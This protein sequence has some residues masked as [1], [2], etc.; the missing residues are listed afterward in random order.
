MTVQVPSIKFAEPKPLIG[1]AFHFSIPRAGAPQTWALAHFP[2]VFFIRKEEKAGGR[3]PGEEGRQTTKRLG[4]GGPPLLPSSQP[5]ATGR[6]PPSPPDISPNP[7][8]SQLS[9]LGL[10]E[11]SPPQEATAG[12]PLPPPPPSAGAAAPQCARGRRGPVACGASGPAERG[13]DGGGPGPCRAA[14]CV[15]PY[16]P[17]PSQGPLASPFQISAGEHRGS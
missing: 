12:A 5:A 4:V 14:R 7:G 2:F 17:A 16:T 1:A 9:D 8:V 6:F 15:P 13:A 11:L 3:A 10:Q